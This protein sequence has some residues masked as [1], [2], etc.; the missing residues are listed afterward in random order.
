MDQIKQGI[1]ILYDQ[2]LSNCYDK[3]AFKED[4]PI[5]VVIVG[6]LF[7]VLLFCTTRGGII[8]KL[9]PTIAIVLILIFSTNTGKCLHNVLGEN[10][11]FF[12][13]NTKDSSF[14]HK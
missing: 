7:S 4:I 10:L 2:L 12:H 11:T 6:I 3:I 1:L 8:D 5:I 9:C 13:R 14:L